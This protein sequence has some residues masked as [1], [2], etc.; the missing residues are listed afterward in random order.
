MIHLLHFIRGEKIFEETAVT[1][2]KID[3]APSSNI[4]T[5]DIIITKFS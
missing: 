1:P 5:E 4:M 2:F 3:A